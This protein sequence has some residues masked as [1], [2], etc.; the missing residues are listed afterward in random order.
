MFALI[1]LSPGWLIFLLLLPAGQVSRSAQPTARSVLSGK[2]C[3]LCGMGDNGHR[4]SFWEWLS[5]ELP[6][7]QQREEQ[8]A[9]WFLPSSSQQSY[10]SSTAREH[11]QIWLISHCCC[12]SEWLWMTFT[13]LSHPCCR[14]IFL[15]QC[16]GILLFSLWVR[17][18]FCCHYHSEL[19]AKSCSLRSPVLA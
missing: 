16:S 17:G 4:P 9:S 1:L 5:V 11:S 6:I 15:S 19:C 7:H 13:T 3:W 8:G 10:Y 12:S 2:L 14:A 18:H